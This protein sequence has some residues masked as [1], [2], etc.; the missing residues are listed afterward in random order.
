MRNVRVL[1]TTLR[2]GGRIIGCAFPDEYIKG[3]VQ[4]LTDAKVD[5][6]EMGFLRGNTEY[7]GNSTMF[8]EVEQF[9][10]FIPKDRQKS[11]YVA[12][13]DYGK[14]Y[15]MWDFSKLP[16]CD[17]TSF[18][19]MRI[20]YRK[21]DL[22]EAMEICKLVKAKGYKLFIQGVESLN[23][24]DR[25]MLEAVEVI[26]QV[27]PDCFGIVDTYGAMYK[28]D[29]LR[30][31]NLVNNNLDENIAI[32]FHSHNNLQ[33]SFSF[34]Q[35]IVEAAAG[36]RE[37]VID[38]TL[39]G[40]GKGIGNL[41]TELIV[42]YLNR[43]HN[44]DY[45]IDAIF[46]ATDEYV[47][48]I[49]RDHTWAY[50]IPYFM[51][52]I[53]SSHANNII[54]LMDKHKLKTKDIKHILSMIEP[55][56]RKRYDYDDI[57]EK[58]ISYFSTKVDDAEDKQRFRDKVRGRN[59]L[60]LAPG[61]S[62]VTHKEDIESAINKKDPVVIT[63]NFIDESRDGSYAFFGN[64]RRY[65]RCRDKLEPGKTIVTSNVMSRSDSDIVINYNDLINRGFK[66]FDNSTVML[67]NLLKDTDCK[68][69][70]IAGFDGFDAEVSHN[71][72]DEAYNETVSAGKHEAA[73][74]DIAKLLVNYKKSLDGRFGIKFVT[75]S[76]F[77]HV[78]EKR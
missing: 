78:F 67:L 74:E 18:T 73:N 54:Y 20:G 53:Y 72:Y 36:R 65:D 45:N 58:Y 39:E 32:D 47:S 46:D 60:V 2:D 76:R 35:E 75:P 55:E 27:K 21:K 69:V 43:K 44:Y 4:G 6:I 41:N 52:G 5:V 57:E 26:N 63:V 38:A 48:W 40:V 11:M 25:E 30:L 15:G 61:S 31:F 28:D 77:E 33:L 62:I 14:E 16:E 37:L 8:T 42:D 1:D 19:G 13:G 34:A 49:K 70:M 22:K 24:T 17:G 3:I 59:V 10:R 9:K 51:A 68:S 23:Y 71:Y 7:K 29:V 50:Q 12:F 66:Y 64:E 56:K